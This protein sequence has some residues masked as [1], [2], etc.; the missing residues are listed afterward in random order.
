MK[1]A[2]TPAT[3]LSLK[4]SKEKKLQETLP[5][6]LDR[7]FSG[8]SFDPTKKVT[9]EQLQLILEAGR[10]APS[11]YNEQPWHFIICDKATD[12][13]AYD[14]L[15][16]TLVEFNQNWV[17][18]VPLLLLG[19]AA[20]TSSHKQKPNRFG[21]YDTGAAAFAMVLRATSLGLMAHQMAGYDDTLARQLFSIPSDY[22]PTSVMAIGH[23]DPSEVQPERK[24][25]PLTENF[26]KGAWGKSITF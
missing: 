10:S 3:S 24:R 20:M 22:V 9:K 18:N 2:T 25:K 16:S 5:H 11:S 15:F 26:F 7:R 14:K 17:K 13:E 8:Y 19:V 12:K 21:Q 1:C 4:Q 6:L 23:G